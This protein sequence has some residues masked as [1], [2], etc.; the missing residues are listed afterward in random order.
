[1]W[2]PLYLALAVG[3]LQ[4]GRWAG[5]QARPILLAAGVAGAA[6]ATLANLN[7]LT[8]RDY[9]FA[10]M[11]GRTLLEKVDPDAVL[12][13]QGDD[14]NGLAGYLQRVRGVRPDVV[15]VGANYL[16][17]GTYDERLLRRHP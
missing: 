9:V 8:Q 12:L 3:A 7:D 16:G 10:E 1:G 2:L 6:W 13:L 4:A 14:A 15:L 11:Y 5:L 17:S